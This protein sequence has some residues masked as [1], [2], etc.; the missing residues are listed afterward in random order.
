MSKKVILVLVGIVLF[1]GFHFA[2]AEVII[3]EVQLFP[4]AERFLELYNTSDSVVDLTGWYMQRKTTTGDSFSS[5]VSKPNF[6]GKTILAHDYFV[7]SRSSLNNSDIV[8]SNLTLAESN[9]IQIKKSEEEVV[10]KVGFGAASDCD[11]PCAPNPGEGQSIQ[12]IGTGSW[13]TSTPTPGEANEAVN[14]SLSNDD[15]EDEEDTEN[16]NTT[17]TTNTNSGNMSKN[18]TTES[19]P[20]VTKNPTMKVKILANTLAFAGEPL[21][22][23][24]SV[25]GYYNEDVV[26]GRAY[27]NFGDGASLEQVNNFEK[28]RHIYYYPGE[29][30][31]YLEYYLNN[32]SKNPEITN[33]MTIKVV[34]TTVIISKVGDIKDFFIE[35]SNNASSE[36]DISN[37]VINA[38]GK[39]FVLPKNSV[40]LPK[41][42]M[43][44]SSKITGF[45]YGDQYNL[46]LFSSTGELVFDYSSPPSNVL[47]VKDKNLNKNTAKSNLPSVDIKSPEKIASALEIE[48]PIKDLEASVIKSDILENNSSNSYLPILISVIFIGV[49]AGAVYSIRQKKV[50][51]SLGDDFKILDE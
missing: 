22:M 35:L 20:K 33:K 51:S 8:L 17:N 24:T 49:S 2:Q 37:W 3:N 45:T 14:T 43:T 13:V 18:T 6:E 28:F 4:T 46:K 27:W 10:D 12:K 42:Q 31:V 41:K 11:N 29:Y 40:I 34:P 23:K 16:S 32:F 39:I 21:E 15:D 26:L 36:I 44:I 5:L 38:N 50:A 7:I 9:T 47:S 25:F 30:V 19:K 1:P 48:I